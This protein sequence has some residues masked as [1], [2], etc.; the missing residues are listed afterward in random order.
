[1]EA[2]NDQTDGKSWLDSN[3]WMMKDFLSWKNT[4]TYTYVYSH[5]FLSSFIPFFFS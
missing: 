1:M 3:I 4:H 2:K 5:F